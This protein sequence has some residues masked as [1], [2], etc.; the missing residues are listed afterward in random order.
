MMTSNRLAD[1]LWMPR[2]FRSRP[3]EGKAMKDER[4]LENITALNAHGNNM[5][6]ESLKY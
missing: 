2:K 3:E 4:G 1:R 5:A 6:T